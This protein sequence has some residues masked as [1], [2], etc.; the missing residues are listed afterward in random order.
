MLVE[1]FSGKVSFCFADL[2]SKHLII[3][4]IYT[5][6]CFLKEKQE[7]ILFTQGVI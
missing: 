3:D 1:Y 2:K 7:V 5:L 4:N 6:L